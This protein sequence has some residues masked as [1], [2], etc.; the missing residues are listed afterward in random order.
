V[1]AQRVRVQDV[2]PEEQE[3]VRYAE[4]EKPQIPS[5]VDIGDARLR[6]LLGPRGQQDH[7]RPENH[8]EQAPHFSQR[9]DASQRPTGHVQTGCPAS[10]RRIVA[11]RQIQTKNEDIHYQNAEQREPAQRI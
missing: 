7:A 4:H 1:G 10:Y 5:V 6:A 9:Q 3:C 11:R 2:A 8:R